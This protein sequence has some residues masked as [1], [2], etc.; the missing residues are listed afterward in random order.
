MN[1]EYFEIRIDETARNSLKEEANL[2]HEEVKRFKTV[3]EVKEY[4]IDRYGKLPNRR[5]KIYQDSN[6][7]KHIE[8]GF[9]HSF[10]NK[11]ISHN[12]K[13]WYQTDWVEICKVNEDRKPIFI[14]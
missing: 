10:W 2:F 3:E 6:E 8:I 12:S 11:D 14:K 4:L 13:S 5:N 1:R 7:G 9:T